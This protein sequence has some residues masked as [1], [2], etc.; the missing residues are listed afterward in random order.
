MNKI[1]Y[2]LGLIGL[3]Y[4]SPSFASPIFFID[5]VTFNAAAA[6]AGISLQTESFESHFSQAPM[7]DFGPFTVTATDNV[8]SSTF[9]PTDGTR[10]IDAD[11]EATFSFEV[12]VNA[13]GI[14][15]IDFGD[16]GKAK[17]I[18][19]GAGLA[20]DM[21]LAQVAN[22]SQKWPDGKI[23]FFGVI[24]S[25]V[26][27]QDF[28]FKTTLNSD[29]MHYDSL[30]FG[31]VRSIPEPS[32]AYLVFPLLILWAWGARQKVR[33]YCGTCPSKPHRVLVVARDDRP[34]DQVER[35]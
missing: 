26:S 6:S 2:V 15:I 22:S 23:L 13:F 35:P 30:S 3:I 5:R 31:T 19:N 34:R 16:A 28:F 18:F 20:T 29:D 33:E 24:D 17:L 14:D 10:S 32:T 12:G 8:I 27:W 25:D 4:L 9:F 21:I 7:V 11:P 1:R